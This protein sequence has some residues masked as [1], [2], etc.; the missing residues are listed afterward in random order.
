MPSCD[1][2][3]LNW[4]F[5]IEKLA[6]RL[7]SWKFWTLS[8]KRKS[9]IINTLANP[10]YGILGLSS[11]CQPGLKRGSIGSSLA[12]CSPE[13]ISKSNVRCVIFLYELGGLK[14]VNVALKCKALLAKSVVFITDG[15]YKAKWVHL[16]R[17][18]VGRALG[19]RHESWG[20][21][22]NNNRPHAWDAPLYYQSVVSAAKGIK[23]VFV[24]S[25]GKS[26]AMKV[27]YADLYEFTRLKLTWSRPDS[28][29]VSPF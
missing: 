28:C 2:L 29:L 8:L 24:M 7:E 12:F 18:F 20:F 21:L 5:Q 26:L 3:S 27:I 1:F 25:V 9:I 17:Y 6:R 4:N 15:Q 23:D 13:K 10:V 11:P 19:K 14:V 22:K 16:A